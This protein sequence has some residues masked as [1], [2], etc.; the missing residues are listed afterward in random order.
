MST[1]PR[2]GLCGITTYIDGQECIGDSLTKINNNFIN[3]ETV[4]CELCARELPF[5][6]VN[7][8]PGPGLAIQKQV[9]PEPNRPKQNFVIS[10]R[11]ALNYVST[12]DMIVPPPIISKDAR[13][14]KFSTAFKKTNVELE[15][16]TFVD[17]VVFPNRN[18]QLA[19][20]FK[21]IPG[22]SSLPAW[23]ID[24]DTGTTIPPA[25]V[26]YSPAKFPYN[27]KW[28][29]A[30]YITV[31][32]VCL[33]N[34]APA[35]TLYWYARDSFQKPTLYATNNCETPTPPKSVYNKKTL[36]FEWQGSEKQYQIITSNFRYPYYVYGTSF[37]G[38]FNC[39]SLM[40]GDRKVLLGG[41]F[42][43]VT[44]GPLGTTDLLNDK[45]KN[46][47]KVR[48]GL[49]TVDLAA[50]APRPEFTAIPG[51]YLSGD[52]GMRAAV[53]TITDF[54]FNDPRLSVQVLDSKPRLIGDKYYYRGFNQHVNRL[55][56]ININNETYL[57]VGGRFTGR[58]A[59]SGLNPQTAGLILFN[60]TNLN[61]SPREFSLYM[62]APLPDGFGAHGL[63]T[64]VVQNANYLYV[65]GMFDKVK[66]ARPTGDYIRAQ[67]VFRI[68]LNNLK[69]DSE[70]WI[71][72]QFTATIRESFRIGNTNRFGSYTYVHFP[73]Q[74]AIYKNILYLAGKHTV[75]NGNTLIYR[76]F[77]VHD[78]ET[79]KANKNYKC[80]F[81][82]SAG[83]PFMPPNAWIPS[84]HGPGNITVGD[85]R[86]EE[87][88]DRDAPGV[89]DSVVLYIAG[90]FDRISLSSNNFT[91]TNDYQVRTAVAAFLLQDKDGDYSANP[92]LMDWS[93][94]TNGVIH[95]VLPGGKYT[96]DPLYIGGIFSRVDGATVKNLAAVTKP[97]RNRVSRASLL[98]WFPN[99][100]GKVRDMVL[101]PASSPAN[102]NL[103]ESDRKESILIVGGFNTVLGKRRL[104]F[105]R[106][107]SYKNELK[108]TGMV[109]PTVVWKV[110]GKC[111][112]AGQD[113]LIPMDNIM[114]AVVTADGGG[115]LN[116]TR[117]PP[118]QEGFTSADIGDI[119]RIYV[120][121]DDY[122]AELFARD[123]YT[124]EVDLV[125]MSLD[126]SGPL[127]DL[128]NY[129]EVYFTSG[130]EV[131]NLPPLSASS[132]V[133]PNE[134]LES[135]INRPQA[136]DVE[137]L[138]TGFSNLNDGI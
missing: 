103:P 137:T 50:A 5:F 61:E 98:P 128:K 6:E 68:N 130:A 39:M 97:S 20:P 67:G 10:S 133:L 49:L 32:S 110:G 3:L 56:L 87:M 120:S 62:D 45:D 79:G 12:G 28:S 118:L 41:N 18:L 14:T 63:A 125:G 121:R 106:V 42:T 48:T 54:Q 71:D 114:T 40:N 113:P 75:Y 117:F 29:I 24:S 36:L 132:G 57:A 15:D 100:N 80:F 85:M 7:I 23:R 17:A 59:N 22:L 129:T 8:Y 27:I 136:G 131:E 115:H 30:P 111:I 2:S 116:V 37:Y 99:P 78:L 25:Q 77:S 46:Q 1:I 16:D 84:I 52:I 93:I 138:A 9:D 83:Q 74:I 94:S 38:Y 60:L 91:K 101:L 104:G 69:G 4:L 47:V 95:R 66:A 102:S 44:G 64:S 126:F 112:E 108:S 65:C 26:Q 70:N 96:D 11:Q 123:T 72:K 21:D 19:N 88:Y 86:I 73:Q 58:S 35:V 105:A 33:A 76:G 90:W 124:G 134:V 31:N 135:G 82:S 109:A 127:P 119:C 107:S 81:S 122:N 34:G 53:S 13:I 51:S 55:T 92:K 43:R 89:V